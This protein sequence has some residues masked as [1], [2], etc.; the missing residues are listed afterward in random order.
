MD[1]HVARGFLV[2]MLIGALVGI[3]RE[4]KKAAAP[5]EPSSGGIRTHILLALAGAASVR[6]AIDLALPWAFVA[7][8]A[9]VGLAVVAGHVQQ[10]REHDD[11]HGLT[12]ELAAIVVFLLAA[13]VMAG[14]EELAV[15]LGVATSALLAFKQPIHGWVRR[16]DTPDLLAGLKLLIASFIVL[17][18]LPD[19]AIDPWAA[20]N[21]YK[22]WLLVIL[23]SA[24]SLAG[25]IAVRW[26]GSAHGAA[27]MGLAGGLVSSTA[28]TLAFARSSS[29]SGGDAHA[30]AAAIL[31]AWLVMFARVLIV[32]GLVNRALL[33]ASWLP[34]LVMGVLT[35]AFAAGHYRRGLA[36][37]ARAGGSAVAVSNPFSLAAAARLGAL[38]AVV[39]LFVAL[40]QRHAPPG[41]VYLVAA[42]AGAVDVD[43]ITLSMAEA[44]GT[45]DRLAQAGI[46]ITIATVANTLLKCGMV[47]VLGAPAL[48]GHIAAATAVLLAGGL[49]ALHLA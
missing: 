14:Q 6:L 27:V 13:M 33:A 2:A 7:A 42:L 37:A 26:L 39:L 47:V 29:R 10:Q 15:A 3:D 45:A 17:P 18:L 43:A 24:L 40:A 19:T 21:P 34:L 36:G 38:F 22:L 20:I 41:G 28:T 12:S 49:L 44:A 1:F 30:L 48:R 46:A 9:V 4:R 11:P 31:L 5:G 32:V 35:A 8:L 25:Y 16:L 23:I